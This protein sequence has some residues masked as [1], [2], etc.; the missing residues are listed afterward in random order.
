MQYQAPERDAYFLMFELF[1]VAEVWQEIPAFSDFS[2]DLIQAVISEGGRIASEVLAPANPIGDEQGCSWDDGEV[3]TPAVFKDA[4]A[5]LSQGGWLGLA[6]NPAFGGQGM[7][8]MV[9]CLIEEMLWAS[10]TSLYLYGT[11]SVGTSVCI[12]GHVLYSAD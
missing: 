6:G 1:R 2:E 5:E 8:K 10:N 9:A 12:D 4:F 11:L 7:P 3:T